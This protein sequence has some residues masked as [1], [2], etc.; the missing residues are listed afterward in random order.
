MIRLDRVSKVFGQTVAVDAVTLEVAAGEVCVLLG[1][2]GSTMKAAHPG[3]PPKPLILRCERSEP[4][5]THRVGA[6]PDRR[7][8][9]RGS[10]LRSSHLSMRRLVMAGDPGLR[11]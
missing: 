1:P 8:V 7:C 11:P 6:A 4:R 5:R 10:S 3:H 9:L 2:S